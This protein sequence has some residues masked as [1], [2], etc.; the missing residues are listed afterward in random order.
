MLSLLCDIYLNIIILINNYH[1]IFDIPLIL[2][3]IWLLIYRYICTNAHWY[4][5]D[6]LLFFLQKAA[7][8]WVLI[9]Y[10]INLS[11]SFNTF[12]KNTWCLSVM[13]MFLRTILSEM[14]ANETLRMINTVLSITCTLIFTLLLDIFNCYYWVVTNKCR[15]NFITCIFKDS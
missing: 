2:K 4:I 10:K 3:S 12:R 11:F 13:Q 8:I 14:I 9:P 5:M 7:I 15:Y 6:S 1:L